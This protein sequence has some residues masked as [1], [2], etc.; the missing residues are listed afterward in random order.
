MNFKKNKA[1]IIF[2]ALM[3]FP[4]GR[5]FAYNPP[6][7]GESL[8][9]FTSPFMLSAERSCA[10][11]ALFHV[12]PG[13]ISENPALAAAEQ[14]VVLD[15]AYTA[16]IAPSQNKN[17]GQ[18]VSAGIIIP[19]RYGVVTG[20][21][22]GVF[23]PFN[24]ML[25]K[26]T[27]TVRAAYSKEITDWL[28]AGIGLYGGFGSDWTAGADIGFVYKPE[29]VS[30]LPFLKKPHFGF[31]LTGMGKNYKPETIGIDGRTDNITSFPSIITPHAGVAGMLFELKGFS[32][33]LSLDV[34]A[35][36]FQNLVIEPGLQF[37]IADMVRLSAGW[38]LNVREAVT[39]TASWYPSVS[40]SVKFPFTSKDESFLSKKGW[41][42]SEMIVA[43]A[44]RPM[45]DNIHA[46]SG[47]AAL[48]LGLKDTAAPEVT[49][50]GK[51]E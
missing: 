30:W 3:L 49:L 41:Q 6:P 33:G 39:K 32:G 45:R 4:L 48:Y 11:G 47:G 19:S 31:S 24:A 35:P 2:T 38:Q 36:F 16:L 43:G 34:S 27:F 46:A 37:L 29:K 25:L 51:D 7:A 40:L 23:V 17:Y 22:Q 20:V 21:V 50:W 18:A 8:Y 9:S 5:T 14:R 44:Y 1:L 13:H 42:Q 26:N 10:G 15:A 28:Y 12:H